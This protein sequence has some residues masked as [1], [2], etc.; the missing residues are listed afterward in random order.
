ALP[1]AQ[2][3]DVVP[4]LVTV[5]AAYPGASGQTVSDT[6]ATPI[7]QQINGVDNK[8]YMESICAADGNMTLNVTFD[9]GSDPNVGQML[10]QNRVAIATP[11]VPDLVQKQGLITNKNNPSILMVVNLYSPR[12]TY[13]AEFLSNYF[14]INICGEL[15][16]L[17]GVA[18]VNTLGRRAYSMRLWLDNTKPQELD[19]TPL[20]AIK[21]VQEQ[22]VRVAVGQLGPPPVPAGRQSVFLVTA[23]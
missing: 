17:P 21:A 20:D 23:L 6:V 18:Q 15:L 4:P 5:T 2:Y 12:G 9:V 1:I 19:L 7:E 8:I 10:V 13:D 16:K 14:K 22:N 11:Q 3:P